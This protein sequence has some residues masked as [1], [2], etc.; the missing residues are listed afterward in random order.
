MQA[1]HILPLPSHQGAL[2]CLS[3]LLFLQCTEGTLKRA[4]WH[5]RA[6]VSLLFPVCGRIIAISFIDLDVALIPN[7]LTIPPL[8]G[9]LFAVVR[10]RM[11]PGAIS[12][13]SRLA[14]VTHRAAGGAGLVLVIFLLYRAVTGRIGMGAGDLTML[15]MIGAY[16][17]WQS[18]VFV[19]FLASIQGLLGAV[20]A[21]V[22]ERVAGKGGGLL[23]RG[24][25]R[26]EYWEGREL[27]E[28]HL[29]LK[30]PDQPDGPNTGP[31]ERLPAPGTE[32]QEP[33]AAGAAPS[34]ENVSFAKT[35][36]PFGPFLGLAALEY[37]FWGDAMER[38][39]FAGL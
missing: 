29:T 19:L 15:A 7:A 39:F 22:R 31:V 17:G 24:V 11:A 34:A 5:H 21:A 27:G 2:A 12:P 26:P 18:L 35:G 28:D 3:V 33:G 32:D 25:H 36:V 1:A 13:S 37:L 9:I 16:L 38:W 14:R 30:T 20:A 10:P 23:L 4:G 6:H 8:V